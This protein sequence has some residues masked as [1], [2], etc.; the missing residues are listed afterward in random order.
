VA[1]PLLLLCRRPDLLP[2]RI[3]NGPDPLEPA[4]LAAGLLRV[5]LSGNGPVIRFH[6]W[7]RKGLEDH[8]MIWV[9]L[10]VTVLLFIYL[11]VALLRPEWF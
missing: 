3:E 6:L 8:D 1:A 5:G 2:R 7:L 10:V 9:S 4:N 11:L